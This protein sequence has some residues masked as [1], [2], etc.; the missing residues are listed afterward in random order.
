MVAGYNEGNY[1]RQRSEVEADYGRQ[2]STNAYSRFLSQQRG[3]RR[4]GDMSRRFGRMYPGA[5]AELAHRGLAGPGVR[6]GVQQEVMGRFIGDYAR[7][8]GRAQQEATQE[9]QQ[10]DLTQQNLDSYR[11]QALDEIEARKAQDIANAAA[12]LEWLRNLVGGL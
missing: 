6:S 3:S 10:Y 12:N 8:Y 9:L 1:V 7:D 11:R 5:R 4:L 2:S